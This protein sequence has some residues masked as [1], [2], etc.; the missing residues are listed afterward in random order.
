MIS[1][2]G[3]LT[4]PE[5]VEWGLFPS[6]ARTA[7]KSGRP[8][9]AKQ[10]SSQSRITLRAE[11]ALPSSW[12]SGNSDVH[13]RPCRVRNDKTPRSTRAWA[14]H[15]SHFTSSAN[16]SHE[17][18][19]V[20]PDVASMGSTNRAAHLASGQGYACEQDEEVIAG[21]LS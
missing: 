6:R 5:A 16:P 1:V 8:S 19:A 11:T 14:Q 12:S 10:T 20:P 17:S 2:A 9:G 18:C 13:A 4:T 7:A 15:P 3:E 21:C